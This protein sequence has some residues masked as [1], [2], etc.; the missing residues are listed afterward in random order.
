MIPGFARNWLAKRD[1]VRLPAPFGRFD[2]VVLALQLS[3]LVGWIVALEALWVGWAL[4][5]A[6]VMA[7]ARL[8][9]RRGEGT[10][11]EPLVWRL[12]L[13]FL[14]MPVGLCLLG[15]SSITPV[16][17]VAAG[18]HALGA[19]AMGSM[20]MVV[21]S[22]AI[23]GRTGQDLVADA[24]TTAVYILAA[25]ATAARI[26]AAFAPDTQPAL[27]WLWIALWMAA[28]AIFTVRYGQLILVM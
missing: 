4:V 11:S 23:L 19:D 10:L 13:G 27:L 1:D 3:A 17:S 22:R 8:A 7:A 21:I 6:G 25:S 16:V 14:W 26:I 28:F 5:G 20:I 15:L 24:W 12:H 9:R 2:G 18:L